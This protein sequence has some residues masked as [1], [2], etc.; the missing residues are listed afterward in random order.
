MVWLPL[1]LDA[2]AAVRSAR[3]F[4]SAW[5]ACED[6]V[7]PSA[8]APQDSFGLFTHGCSSLELPR[9]PITCEITGVDDRDGVGRRL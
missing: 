2:A 8:V 3:V 6:V 9:G 5:D 1:S 7:W 4:G